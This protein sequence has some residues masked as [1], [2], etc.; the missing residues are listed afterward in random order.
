M[1]QYQTVSNI[2]VIGVPEGEKKDKS[3]RKKYIC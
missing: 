3:G 1:G 2:C